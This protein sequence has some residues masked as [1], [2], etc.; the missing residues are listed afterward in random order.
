MPAEV[1]ADPGRHDWYFRER[2]RDSVARFIRAD[3]CAPTADPRV[4]ALIEAVELGVSLVEQDGL[5]N[6]AGWDAFHHAALAALRGAE[7]GDRG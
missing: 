6:D 5:E 4:K 7:G 1:F 3:L 2:K